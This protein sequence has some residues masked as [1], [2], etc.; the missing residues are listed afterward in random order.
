MI[1]L[2]KKILTKGNKFNEYQ[3]VSGHEMEFS[4]VIFKIKNTQ[5]DVSNNHWL[6]CLEPATF[7]IWLPNNTPFEIVAQA[8]LIFTKSTSS[9][10]QPYAKVKLKF[11]KTITLPEGNLHLFTAIQTK[12]YISNPLFRSIYYHFYYKKPGIN[13]EKFKVLAAAFCYPRKVRLISYQEEGHKNHFPMDLLGPILG[14]QHYVLGLRH[15]NPSLGKILDS[16]KVVVGEFDIE[17]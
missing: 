15:S 17:M 2:L 16:K 7:G 12:L 10:R 1:S 3:A 8:E 4:T 11:A 14:T 5:L 9:R 13:H 6:L